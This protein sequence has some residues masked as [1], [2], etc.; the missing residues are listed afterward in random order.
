MPI[1]MTPVKSSQIHSIGHD[2]ATNTL[3]IRFNGRNNVPGSLYHYSNVTADDFAAFSGAESV[4]SHFYRN[5]KPNTDKFPYQRINEE[6][7]EA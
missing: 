4:G 7:S 2:A 3:A 5:I 1:V 6:K